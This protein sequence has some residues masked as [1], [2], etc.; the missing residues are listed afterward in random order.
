MAIH[1][2]DGVS[3]ISFDIWKTL[4]R[5]NK[6][7]TR[8]RLRFIFDYIGLAEVDIEA[9]RSAYLE[10]D[11]FFNDEAE[12]TGCDFGMADRLGHMFG[13]LDISREVPSSD[14]VEAIQ[15]HLGGLRSQGEYLPSLIEADLPRTLQQLSE[16]GIALGL[17]SNTGMDNSLVMHPVLSRLGILDYFQVVVFSS[18]DGRAKPNPGLFRRMADEFGV[19][20]EHVLHIGDNPNADYRAREAGLRSLH[21]APAGSVL[22][23]VRSMRELLDA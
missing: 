2:L 14:E 16:R 10:A 20:A 19:S 5:G 18:E 15:L 6:N 17:L 23:H 1:H 7:F 3:C 21:Y 12:I 13:T 8:P 22:E 4:L 11:S 9:I